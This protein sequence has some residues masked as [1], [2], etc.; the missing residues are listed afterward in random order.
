[1]NSVCDPPLAAL[2]TRIGL[3][4]YIPTFAREEMLLE[5]LLMEEDPRGVVAKIIPALGP[6]IRLANALNELKKQ[7]FLPTAPPATP[8]APAAA[9]AA[10]ATP[11]PVTDTQSKDL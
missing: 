11:A 2:L 7:P 4:H 1:M 9:A 10:T 3:Q 5:W 8:A 6:Q